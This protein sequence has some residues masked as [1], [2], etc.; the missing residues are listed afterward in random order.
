MKFRIQHVLQ[1][2]N[3]SSVAMFL[4]LLSYFKLILI[5]VHVSKQGMAV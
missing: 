4:N 3:I 5:R 2:S 1:N